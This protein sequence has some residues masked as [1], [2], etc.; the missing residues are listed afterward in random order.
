M[1]WL[2]AGAGL[3]ISFPDVAEKANEMY[4]YTEKVL[5]VGNFETTT[6]RANEQHSFN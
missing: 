5:G 6:K 1:I 3:L 4:V 2:L